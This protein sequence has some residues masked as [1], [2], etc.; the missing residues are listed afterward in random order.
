M[1]QAEVVALAGWPPE[2]LA[3]AFAMYSRSSLSIRESMM[4]ITLERT[5]KFLETFYF[6]Y[7]HASIADNAHVPLALENIPQIA[8][9]E[10]EDESLIDCQERSTRYQL[11]RKE[12]TE[13][14]F[15]PKSVR[16]TPLENRFH[17]VAQLNLGQYERYTSLCFE[18]LA[19]KH[20]KP[21]EMKDDAYE[22]TLKA[23][24][25]DVARYFLFNGILTSVGQITSARTLARQASRLGASRYPDIRDLAEMM[26]RACQE[27]PFCPEGK[28]EPPV[29]P[30]LMKHAEPNGYMIWTRDFVGKF[31]EEHVPTLLNSRLVASS[32]Y[33][34]QSK[35]RT[36][37]DEI[38][39]SLIYEVVQVP[40]SAILGWLQTLD[41]ELLANTV[42]EVL[43][44]R[45]KHDPLPR[46]F[47]EGMKYQFDVLMDVGGR[48]DLHRHR[49]CIQ[50]HQNLTTRRGFDIPPLLAEMELVQ[51]FSDSLDDIK[52]KILDIRDLLGRDY[53]TQD[54]DYLI[55]F[56]FRAGTVYKMHLAELLYIT[57]LR[58]GVKGHFSY[59][60]IACRMDK[61]IRLEEPF[62]EGLTR[63]TPLEEEDLLTR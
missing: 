9:F 29:A 42:Q 54:A 48:R 37:V 22:R 18:Y 28:D 3:F 53:Q 31:V 21:A 4:K 20:P 44:Q 7:S 58:S 57:E 61:T 39:A 34:R 26:K 27:K 43:R 41:P 49:N 6:Q 46:A 50:I 10:V 2:V 24:S 11:F 47:A 15:I 23:R 55:P 13:G 16:G 12:D 19:K 59:R 30:T 45:G 14:Y 35:P 56:A 38:L 1:T 33:A 25:F 8:A 62:L 17:E 51:E 5:E 60:D 36:A 32:R 63:V 52:M 40:Y